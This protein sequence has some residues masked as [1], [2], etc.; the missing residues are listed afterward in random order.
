LSI[1]GYVL[2]E[3]LLPKIYSGLWDARLRAPRVSM[4][5]ATVNHDCHSMFR[6]HNIGSSGQILPVQPKPVS[7][8]MKQAP[9]H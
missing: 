3:F 1:S 5:K 8:P 9:N 7:E 4:P 6:Q 2:A